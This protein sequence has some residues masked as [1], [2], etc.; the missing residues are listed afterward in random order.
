MDTIDL[1]GEVGNTQYDTASHRILANVQSRDQ[2]VVIDPRTDTIVERH[3]L[4]G[5]EG[6]HGLLIPP[7]GDLAFA[8]CEDDARL[9]VVDLQS[10]QVKQVVTTGDGPDVL[11]FDPGLQRL[12]VATESGTVSVFQLRDGVLTRLEDVAVGARAHSV[13]VNP[14]NHEV[15]LPLPDVEG[16]PVLRIMRAV[17]P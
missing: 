6:P 7:S 11:A 3:T 17:T 1:G 8:A 2:V 15:Y 12:Y 14:E 16:H 10:F 9:L 4:E 5:G 13:S